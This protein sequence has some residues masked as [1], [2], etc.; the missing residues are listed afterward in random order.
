MFSDSA[1][2]THLLIRTLRAHH[3]R[4][5]AAHQSLGIHPGQ[6]PVFFILSSHEGLNQK[7]LA[8]KMHIKPATLTV[9]LTRLEQSGFVERFSDPSDQRVWRIRLT[10][11]GREISRRV[12]DAVKE[13]DTLTF[14]NFSEE[15]KSEFRHLMEKMYRNL[16]ES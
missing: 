12:Q 3:T 15:E 9:M 13:I 10:P 2:L 7:E 4:M 6:A 5:H 14:G 16:R 1:E 8:D 11:E